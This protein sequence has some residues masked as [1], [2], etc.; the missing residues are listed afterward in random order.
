V[1]QRIEDAIFDEKGGNQSLTISTS[2]LH[3]LGQ[4]GKGLLSVDKE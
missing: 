1:R 4:S 2:M 3:Y